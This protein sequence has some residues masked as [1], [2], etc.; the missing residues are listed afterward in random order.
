MF[1]GRGEAVG[2]FPLIPGYSVVGEVVDVGFAVKGR[3]VGD[4][5]SGRNPD[6]PAPGLELSAHWAPRGWRRP[7][8]ALLD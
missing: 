1:S 7:G 6:K 5:V 4:L 8:A 3:Q 2:K